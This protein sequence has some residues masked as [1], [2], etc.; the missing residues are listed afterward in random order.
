MD[1]GW[2]LAALKNGEDVRREVWCELVHIPTEAESVR[3]V[4]LAEDIDPC[5][6]VTA[7]DGSRAVFVPT[8]HH[9]MAEDW[10]WA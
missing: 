6:V 5:L 2:A 9:L 8:L 1:F 3:M 7:Y 10:A 4:K